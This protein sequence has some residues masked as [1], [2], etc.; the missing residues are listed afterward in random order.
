MISIRDMIDVD[1]INLNNA[2]KEF[3]VKIDG[4][5]ESFEKML[6]ESVSCIQKES[7]VDIPDKKIKDKKIM[8]LCV[9]M[10]SI[11]VGRMLKE[12]RKTVH[13]GELINGGF[14]E[15]VFE[16]MLYDEYELNL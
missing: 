12:M 4:K 2:N 10:E 13:K 7:E 11:L 8:D 14:A 9:Q 5:G 1:S 16:D 3:T 6:K 15:E